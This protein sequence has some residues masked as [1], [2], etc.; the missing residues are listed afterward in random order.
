MDITAAKR[1][2]IIDTIQ[3][4]PNDTLTE[5][6]SFVQQLRDRTTRQPLQ[7]QTLNAEQFNQLSKQ[8][9]ELFVATRPSTA[10]PLSDYAVSRE[11][12]YGDHP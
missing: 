10:T 11:G 5:L 6:Q 8:L 3:S 9:I 7:P 4:L 1:Q 12:I 2:Q